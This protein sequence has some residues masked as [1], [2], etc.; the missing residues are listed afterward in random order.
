MF[1]GLL[2]YLPILLFDLFT[3]YRP[4]GAHERKRITGR[5]LFYMAL[6]FDL[7]VY[8]ASY[9]LLIEIFQFTKDFSRDYKYTVGESLKKETIELLTLIFRANRKTDKQLVL[10]EARERIE[11]IRLFIRLMKVKRFVKFIKSE[12]SN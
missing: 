12:I 10:Q 5:F 1:E 8:K 3:A 4:T 2:I 11:V 7:P 6:Y 9:D